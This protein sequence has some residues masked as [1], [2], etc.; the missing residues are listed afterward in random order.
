[1]EAIKISDGYYLIYYEDKYQIRSFEI[2][3]FGNFLKYWKILYLH[4]IGNKINKSDF[5]DSEFMNL[6]EWK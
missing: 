6:F 1:M 3:G 2:D 4:F 5:V